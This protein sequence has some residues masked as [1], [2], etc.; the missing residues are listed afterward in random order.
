MTILGERLAPALLDRYLARTGYRAQQT[1]EPAPADARDNFAGPLPGD[2]GAHGRFGDR[3][4]ALSLTARA[5]EAL[6]DAAAGLSVT[7]DRLLRRGRQGLKPRQVPRDT[8]VS[9]AAR[10]GTPG[11]P[12]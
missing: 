4:A 3:S 7:G 2:R 9:R 1:D 11:H 5:R 8:D 6:G 12:E 10:S